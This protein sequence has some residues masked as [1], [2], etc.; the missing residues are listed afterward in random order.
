MNQ[1]AKIPQ[2]GSRRI[3]VP[4]PGLSHIGVEAKPFNPFPFQV[5]AIKWLTSHPRG[6]FALDQGLGKTVCALKAIE[7]LKLKTLVICPASVKMVWAEEAEKWTN[8]SYQVLTSKSDFDPS[9]DLTIFNYDIASKVADKIPGHWG[10]VVLDESHFVKNPKAKRTKA[11]LQ[12]LQFSQ[13]SWALSGTPIPNRPIEI[14]ALLKRMGITRMDYREFGYRYCGAWETPWDTFDV[15]GH[16]NLDELQKKMSPHTLR[17]KKETVLKDLPPKT[18]QV[19]ALD[20]PLNKKEKKFGVEEF[21]AAKRPTDIAGLP[22]IL[23]DHGKRKIEPAAAHIL[24]LLKSKEKVLVFAYHK[25]VISQLQ[26][27]LAQEKI[28]TWTLTGSHS[29][30]QRKESVDAFQKGSGRV[31][32]A[33]LIAGKVGLTLTASDTVVFVEPS[34]SPEVIFQAVDRVHRIGQTNPVLAQFL[35]IHN[36]ID[37]YQIRRALEKLEVVSQIIKENPIMDERFLA[38][39]ESIAE[40]LAT[41][42]DNQGSKTKRKRRTKEEIAADKAAEEQ[43]AETPSKETPAEEQVAET[44]S[45]EAP[46]EPPAEPPAETSGEITTEDIRAALIKARDAAGMDAA[47]ATIAKFGVEKVTDIPVDKYPDF[48]AACDDLVMLG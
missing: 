40:S 5:S 9:R 22:E 20:L 45:K 43:A 12:W 38:A 39:M 24:D 32:I 42:A 10:I 34:W 17:I 46:A 29:D 19:V 21:K 1:V 23:Q 11:A 28:E 27:A 25:E 35:T 48:I 14:Y 16:S 18:Y 41:I 33:N 4:I 37:E 3:Q 8:L 6:I 13:Y 15:S 44:P 31:L 7:E 2:K 30:K 47:K 26:L 36:S